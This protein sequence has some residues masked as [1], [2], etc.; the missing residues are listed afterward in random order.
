MTQ[1]TGETTWLVE[2]LDEL[3]VHS[4]KACYIIL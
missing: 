1:A 3:G 4:S 2:L